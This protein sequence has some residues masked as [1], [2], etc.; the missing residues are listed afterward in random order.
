MFAT[1]LLATGEEEQ[2][3]VP[4]D[5]IK[6]EGT[7]KRMFLARDGEAYEMVV[8]TGVEKDG[9]VAVLE[10]IQAGEKVI[11]KPPPGL[12]DGTSIQ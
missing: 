9:R 3:T 1:V 11:V 12:R 6:S 5:A 2:P 4:I 7:I 10:P 8:R